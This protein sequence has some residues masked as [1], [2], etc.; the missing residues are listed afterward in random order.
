MR[1]HCA[2]PEASLRH[3]PAVTQ[4]RLAMALAVLE[5]T[6][7]AFAE[8]SLSPASVRG[9][10]QV[11]VADNLIGNG[12][13]RAKRRFRQAHGQ[14]PPNFLTISPS[15]ACNLRCP[16]CYAASGASPEKLEWAVLDRI[17]ADAKRDWG[18]RMFVLSGGEPL[19]YRDGGRGVL[20]LAEEHGDCFFL[21]YTN[22]TLIDETV[23]RRLGRLGNLS[24]AL[25]AEGLRE[26][27]DARRGPGVFD[28]LVEAIERLRAQ[29][30]MFGLSLTATR[31]NANEILSDEVIDFF[32]GRMAAFYGWI[33]QYMPIGRSFTL[34]LMP[35]PEQRV[36]LW[37]R[38]WELVRERRLFLVDFW[39]SGAVQARHGGVRCAPRGSHR[40]RLEGP[41]RGQGCGSGP[42]V[43]GGG[44]GR[45][46]RCG[47]ESAP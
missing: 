12:D 14:S 15:R 23:A 45:H 5:A 21:M 26:R 39:N 10:V 38:T 6:E 17:V 35:T 24:P 44:V 33:F 31:E 29:G 1:A 2:L 41:V 27:T 16:G 25:S 32:F 19:A 43:T 8:R 9:L 40:P 20:D 42:A 34:A 36:R 46:E 4:D 7:R 13:D 11:L 3:L 30:V 22:G 18:S 47:P 28:R 37:Q